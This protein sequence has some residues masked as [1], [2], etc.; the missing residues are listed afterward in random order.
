MPIPEKPD[1][2]TLK[3]TEN[4]CL[5]HQCYTGTRVKIFKCEESIMEQ[6]YQ[7]QL[8]KIFVQIIESKKSSTNHSTIHIPPKQE[9]HCGT[10]KSKTLLSTALGLVPRGN[11]ARTILTLTSLARNKQST[12]CHRRKLYI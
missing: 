10:S 5:E 12:A 3:L 8:V 11:I 7:T 2:D 1:L 9:K 6:K 4:F